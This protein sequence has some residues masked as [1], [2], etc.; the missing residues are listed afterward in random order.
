MA[1]IKESDPDLVCLQE[2]DN[3]KT[4]YEPFLNEMGYE[5]HTEWRREDNDA[6]LIGYKKDKFELRDTLHIQYNDLKKRFRHSIFLKS[7]TAIVAKLRLK[8][9]FKD[10]IVATTHI[11]WNPKLDFIKYGQMFY[12]FEKIQKFDK[13]VK[14]NKIP[15]IICGDFNS[16]QDSSM[17][18]FMKGE[19]VKIYHKVKEKHEFLYEK[20]TE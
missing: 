10:F 17:F 19:E 11:H 20:I 16:N 1:E 14:G 5:C 8:A 13:R 7:N 6:V 4:V 9:T 2:V 12:L 15:V 3:Y 18:S